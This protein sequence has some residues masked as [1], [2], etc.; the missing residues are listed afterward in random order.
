MDNHLV[1]RV[2]LIVAAG[3]ALVG[4]IIHY[5]SVMGSTPPDAYRREGFQTTNNVVMNAPDFSQPVA[6][7]P[8]GAEEEMLELPAPVE[9]TGGVRPASG[10]LADQL[11][12]D[13]L[14]P[15][16]GN[17]PEEQKFA[18]LYS[19]GQGDMRGI[20]F[21]DAGSQIGVSTRYHRN[22][23]LQLRSDPPIHKQPLPFM[24]S[25]IE[26]DKLRLPLEIGSQASAFSAGGAY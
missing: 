22:G 21:L 10:S 1:F 7:G 12:P 9:Q 4:I 25:T 16:V 8:M 15:R 6:G 19:T 14:L 17:S 13:D 24:Y 20:N 5:N 18:Q 26:A 3:I 23:N 11:K 2:L